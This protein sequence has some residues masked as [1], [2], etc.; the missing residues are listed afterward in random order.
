MTGD[1]SVVEFGGVIDYS[2]C[3]I[4]VSGSYFEG[5]MYSK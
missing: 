5:F 1:C 3:T 4:N 2:V